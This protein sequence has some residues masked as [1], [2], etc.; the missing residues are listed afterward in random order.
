MSYRTIFG[1]G[2]FVRCLRKK[3]DAF[4]SYRET[5]VAAQHLP[6]DRITCLQCSGCDAGSFRCRSLKI[7]T[8]LDLPR[9]CVY[10]VPIASVKDQRTGRERWPQLT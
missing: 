1:T 5:S 10:F 7:G 9:R 8:I 3:H 2:R 4:R 6:D